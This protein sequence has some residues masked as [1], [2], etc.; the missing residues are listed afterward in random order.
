MKHGA[1]PYYGGKSPGRKTSGWIASQLPWSW[2]SLY[3]EPFCGMAG[4]W[5]GR[6]PVHWEILNDVHDRLINWW[7]VV[8]D[9]PEEFGRRID[10]THMHS[11]SEFYQSLDQLDT[12]D[13]IQRAV[14]Y[15]VVMSGSI[16]NSDN[17]QQA[18]WV[19]N[20]S[21]S[22]P[23]PM[24]F[25]SE[26]VWRIYERTRGVQIECRDA[27]EMLAR[28]AGFSHAVVYVDPP[29]RTA[30]TRGY[31]HMPDWG[32]LTDVLA[33]Q[34]GSVA[35]SGYNDEWDHLG[36]RCTSLDTTAQ[37]ALATGGRVEKLW[38]N[39]DQHASGTL[40]QNNF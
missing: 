11:R 9:S 40:F 22:V 26:D 32:A 28:I 19:P 36:W 38:M 21:V 34:Q 20:Y 37:T 2:E 1:L 7:R 10:A 6:K 23:R 16:S 15:T 29:Y 8:R 17:Y 35:V 25:C 31:I 18:V 27:V 30:D 4:V 13:S 39:Y 33:E 5:Y 24:P 12:G 14:A 3:V